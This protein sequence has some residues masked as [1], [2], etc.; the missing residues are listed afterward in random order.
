MGMTGTKTNTLLIA[1]IDWNKTSLSS[2]FP[3]IEYNITN[4]DDFEAI[5][6][7]SKQ[8]GTYFIIDPHKGYDTIGILSFKTVDS[9]EEMYKILN[10]VEVD[11][12]TFDLRFIDR[13]LTKNL[14]KKESYTKEDVKE[15]QKSDE[16]N[17]S[18]PI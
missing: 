2:I 13:K 4:K 6:L 15:S 12:L 1:N 5:T 10:D 8:D 3:I 18:Q 16:S 9:A 11:S 7:Y 14:E 17:E